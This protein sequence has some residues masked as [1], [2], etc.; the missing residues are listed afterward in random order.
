M[1]R[2]KL[3]I[4]VLISMLL[5][6]LIGSYFIYSFANVKIGDEFENCYI[7]PSEFP[8]G[9]YYDNIDEYVFAVSQKTAWYPYRTAFYAANG[10]EEPVEIARTG[11][12]FTFYKNGKAY[13][14]Y[15]DK[16]MTD[17]V[18]AQLS[19]LTPHYFLYKFDYNMDNNSVTP[20]YAEFHGMGTSETI[21]VL[22]SND[23]AQ[24]SVTEDD[25]Y[26]D[27][28]FIDTDE[29]KFR[30]SC[31]AAID[32]KLDKLNFNDFKDE[33][34]SSSTGPESIRGYKSVEFN[35]VTYYCVTLGKNNLFME[36]ISS[37]D[38]K[39]DMQS[40]TTLF[41]SVAAV[42]YITINVY[43][44]KSKRLNDAKLAF[45]S[46]AAHE[47]KTPIAAIQ[48]NS[49]CIIEKVAPD[50]N[51]KYIHTIYNESLRMNYLV[52]RLLQYNRL[53]SANRVQK[54]DCSLTDIVNSEIENYH[55]LIEDRHIE[56]DTDIVSNA[57][58]K[59]NADLIALAVD[60]FLSNA[61][62]N[63]A[64]NEKITVKLEKYILGYRFSVFNQ[65]KQIDDEV[66]NN[67]WD[68]FYRTDTVRNSGEHS[69]GMGLA[70]C[71]QIFDLHNC[72]YGF[73]NKSNGVEFYFII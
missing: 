39:N 30:H 61:V 20:V 33:L 65:G 9:E 62:K 37:A 41:I 72:K 45:I 69:V 2:K 27:R 58:I 4:L 66:R 51:D 36:T 12:M 38:F 11:S 24:Y 25:G 1:S 44:T 10:D 49:E 13:Y 26:I 70:I 8:Q 18:R 40:F 63:T 43:F 19:L 3:N 71:K 32:E 22:F 55:Q 34:D 5:F 47:L 21:N 64:C 6:Y 68:I 28:I 59:A 50:K 52:S 54:A 7:S 23:E 73:E 31:Y 29:P 46:A 57:K 56:L 35:G 60:N 17:E 67:I 53:V 14:C 42:F 15:L 16:Y 48:N